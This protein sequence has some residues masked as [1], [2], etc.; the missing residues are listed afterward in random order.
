MNMVNCALK[1]PLIEEENED[2]EYD[3]YYDE[4][5]IYG[6]GFSVRTCNC[7]RRAGITSVSRLKQMTIGDLKKI[8]NLDSKS[9]DEIFQRAELFS[10]N[11][12]VHQGVW[13]PSKFRIK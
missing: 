3:E 2:D 10:A 12:R 9:L 11:N 8:S 1:N 6:L 13:F 4:D 7:L 5:S